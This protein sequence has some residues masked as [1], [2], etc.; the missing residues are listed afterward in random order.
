MIFDIIRKKFLVLT[1]E[2]WVRQHAI[3]FLISY[4]MYPSG[5]LRVEGGLRVNKL[6]KRSDIVVYNPYGKP[7]M[8]IECKSYD[9][10]LTRDTFYQAAMYNSSLKAEHI[11]LTNGLQHL[12]GRVHWHEMRLEAL[13][14]IPDYPKS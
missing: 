7:W 14:E 9:T 5:M 4:K 3:N 12:C 11:L 13:S 2:E 10:S 6:L 8:L 1:P